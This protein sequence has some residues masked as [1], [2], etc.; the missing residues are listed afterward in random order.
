[1]LTARNVRRGHVEGLA[2][3]RSLRQRIAVERLAEIGELAAIVAAE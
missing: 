1:V 3:A 2:Q